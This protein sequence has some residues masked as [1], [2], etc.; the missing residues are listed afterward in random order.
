MLDIQKVTNSEN[1]ISIALSESLTRCDCGKIRLSKNLWVGAEHQHY[2]TFVR[3][4]GSFD[5][6]PDCLR[7]MMHTA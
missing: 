3:M 6:C 4:V 1:F 2:W 5:V 7:K